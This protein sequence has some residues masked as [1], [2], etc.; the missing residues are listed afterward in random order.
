M[1]VLLIVPN[2]RS[3]DFMP[4]LSLAV[5]KGYINEKTRHD[6]EIVDL[7][8]HKR[9]WERYLERKIRKEKPDLIGFSVLSFNYADALLIA[10]YIKKNFRLLKSK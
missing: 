3:Y 1:K 8:S 6:A 7:L 5:L 10:R 4:C 2:I 9:D